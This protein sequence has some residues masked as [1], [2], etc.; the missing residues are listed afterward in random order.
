M[1]NPE[2]YLELIEKEFSASRAAL[3]EGNTGRVRVCARRAAGHAIAWL[4]SAEP[5][6]DWGTDAMRQLQHLR[7]DAEFPAEVRDAARR[8]TAKVTESFS[9]PDG[10]DPLVDA[11]LIIH[12]LR[13]RVEGGDA[14]AH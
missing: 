10:A 6:A 9:Y 5:R 3:G 2:H 4:L 14:G 11:G 1:P 13:S 12:H 7:D 8:L